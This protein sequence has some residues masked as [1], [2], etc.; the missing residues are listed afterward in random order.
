MKIRKTE[1][2]I[3]FVV[4][5]YYY[6]FFDLTYLHA[7][8]RFANLPNDFPRIMGMNIG[9]KH[10]D[11]ESYQ[12]EL[13]KNHIVILGF[14]R[15]WEE[16]RIFKIDDVLKKMKSYNSSIKIGQYTIINEV[17]S[18]LG[19]K[20]KRDIVEKLE[21]EQWW[22]RDSN[23]KKMQWTNKYNAWEVNITDYVKPDSEGKRF[24]QWIAE[25][26][27]NVFFRTNPLFEIWYIDNLFYMPRIHEADW[28]NEKHN[29]KS[30]D[31]TIQ[32][33]Y[34]EG[35]VAYFEKAKNLAPKLLFIVNADSDLHYKEFTKRFH[36]AFLEGL[37]GYS[38]SLETWAG[39]EKMMERYHKVFHHLIDPK[40]V[41][42]HVIGN[43]KD[44]QFFRYSYGSCLLNDGYYC[45]SDRSQE[46]SSVVWFDE[47]NYRLGKPLEGP[48]IEPWRGKL[49]RRVFERAI[50][51]VN[52]GNIEEFVEIDQNYQPIENMIRGKQEEITEKKWQKIGPKD[53]AIFIK[54]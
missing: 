20:A 46:Y 35:F 7:D 36:G 8:E 48:K 27:Y 43:P 34:R 11:E 13:S 26:N 4:T 40:I 22:L 25:R 19:D 15:G 2:L 14:Y 32:K 9:K 5:I 54:K 12:K 1:I 24:P 30:S 51:Y 29:I 3:L 31:E 41:G 17:T 38:W 47:F 42:F 10:Y 23:K 33:A 21:K 6:F 45:F 16:N 49:Y 39:W 44:K 52:P 53:G 50:V 18:D 28:K 37:M